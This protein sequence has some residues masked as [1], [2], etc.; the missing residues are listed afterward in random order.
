MEK[1]REDKV[2]IVAIVKRINIVSVTV[3]ERKKKIEIEKEIV[4]IMIT[5][6]VEVEVENVIEEN[7][8]VKEEV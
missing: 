6:E 4:M 5:Q 1:E 2:Q 3:I 7:E 8:V